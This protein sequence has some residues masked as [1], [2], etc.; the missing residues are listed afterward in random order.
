M[1]QRTYMAKPSNT[2]I[3]WYVVDAKGKTLGRLATE[4]AT[5]LKGKHRPTYTPHM[6]MGDHVIVINAERIVLTGK[7]LDQKHHYWHSGYP[8]GI[9]DV[10]YR[11]LMEKHPERAVTYAVKGMLPKNKLG[12]QMMRKLRVYRGEEHPH[13]AQQPEDLVLSE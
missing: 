3:K 13:Q 1:M 8:G 12:A 10:D 9:K 6:D 11:T 2:E 4:V 5:I 7:K